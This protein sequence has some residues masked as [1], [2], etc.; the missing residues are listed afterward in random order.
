MF[1]TLT[2]PL[3]GGQAASEAARSAVVPAFRNGFP[4][5]PDFFPIGVWLQSPSNAA[6]FRVL[7]INTFVGLW[8]GPTEAQLRD[9]AASG[10]FVVAEQNEVGLRSPNAGIIKAWMQSDEPDNAQPAAF[11]YGP[12]IPASSVAERSRAL[13]RRA[14]TRPV[15]IN[16]GQG[17]ANPAWVGRGAC[18]GDM[19]YYDTAIQGADILSFDIYPAASDIAAVRGKLEYVARGV[20]ELVRRAAPGQAVWAV[21]ETTFIGSRQRVSALELRAEVWM[22]LTHGAKGVL[23]FVHEWTGG[24]REDGIFRHPGIVEEVTRDNRLIASL[25]PV[26]N[27]KTVAG[28]VKV[29]TSTIS[30]M[31]KQYDKA[32]Y[33]FCV[34]M[35]KAGSAAR[36]ETS[37]PSARVE[38][39]G[40]NRTLAMANGAFA[41][42]FAGYGVHLYRIGLNAG[43]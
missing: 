9:L 29:S 7:G 41:D 12:C 4:A 5:A 10:M 43:R 20:D 39:I 6:A 35:D 32:M 40:E 2:I 30:T 36:F 38:V 33:V 17:V 21:L 27:S 37:L 16:F 26:L 13:K 24:F 18:T 34:A 15:M 42:S 3:E 1:L 25:A 8:Q 19:A 11:G 31:V 28:A 14:A 23:Y 22:A